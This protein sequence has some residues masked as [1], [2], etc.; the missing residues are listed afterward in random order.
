MLWLYL[1]KQQKNKATVQDRIVLFS[2]AKV[3]VLPIHPDIQSV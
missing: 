1:K 2:A 3:E